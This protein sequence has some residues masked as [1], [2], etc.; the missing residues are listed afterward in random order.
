[1][2]WFRDSDLANFQK[3]LDS[4]PAV[5][6]ILVFDDVSFLSGALGKKDMDKIKHVMTEVRHASTGVDY[7]TVLFFSFHYSKGLDKYLRDTNFRFVTS[8]GA[9]ELD[10]YAALFGHVNM[11]SLKNYRKISVAFSRGKSIKVKAGAGAAARALTY[12]YREPFGLALYHDGLAL[13]WMVYPGYDLVVPDLCTNCQHPSARK[14][15][16]RLQMKESDHHRIHAF[17]SQHCGEHTAAQAARLLGFARYGRPMYVNGTN[18]KRA[19]EIF[20]RLE[21]DQSFSL[22]SYLAAM[23]P[24]NI[25]QVD[26]KLKTKWSTYLSEEIQSDYKEKFGVDA[27]RPISET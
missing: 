8:M 13:R 2:F 14:R 6:R 10:N 23:M 26:G 5:N 20:R 22:D 16:S 15:N 7:R 19:L 17:V 4:L 27:L 1:M 11:M 18:L 21:R 3:T 9:E 24:K 25:P 12:R